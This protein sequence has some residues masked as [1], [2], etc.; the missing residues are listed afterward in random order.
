MQQLGK[1]LD[2][3]W[4]I[5]ERNDNHEY[6]LEN[7]YNHERMTMRW[8]LIRKIEQGKTTVSNVRCLRIA[9]KN[10]QTKEKIVRQQRWRIK[11]ERKK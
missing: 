11:E 1:I 4:E 3:M 8:Q 2:G 9:R 5:K 7:I 10:G 6:I